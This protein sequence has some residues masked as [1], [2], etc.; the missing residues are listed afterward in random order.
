MVR[1]ID[2]SRFIDPSHT[3][4]NIA[5][6]DVK[7]HQLDSKAAEIIQTVLEGHNRI[8]ITD[9]K[10]HFH[11][12][13]K[14]ID[15][16]DFLGGGPKYS[17]FLSG[18]MNT[19]AEAIMETSVEAVTPKHTTS[20]VLD[21]MKKRN[22]DSCPLLVGTKFSGLVSEASF[23]HRVRGRTGIQV[24]DAMVHKPMIVKEHMPVADVAGIMVRA[25]YRRLP[26]ATKGVLLGIVTP[27]D[28]ISHLKSKN[29]FHDLKAQTLPVT[30][31]MNANVVTVS[32][33]DDL[34][35]AI[36]KMRSGYGCLP[37]VEENEL[38]G[39][40]TERDVLELLKP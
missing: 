5:R 29:A 10:M 38:M 20:K 40:I 1:M 32:P 37:V 39:I 27:Y 25:R 2:F 28:I 21:G 18:R 12:M 3:I 19:K 17:K 8:P 9:E 35:V 6:Q 4:T 24:R 22:I 14:A 16:L 13:I 23:V 31:V 15:V 33:E 26:V 7:T 11:G 30:Q 36:D 34:A